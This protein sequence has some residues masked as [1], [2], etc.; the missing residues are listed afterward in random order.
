MDPRVLESMLARTEQAMQVLAEK[1]MESSQNR[2]STLPAVAH[3][4]GGK[5]STHK[6]L[7]QPGK[8]ETRNA[9]L[10]RRRYIELLVARHRFTIIIAIL[11]IVAHACYGRGG[12]QNVSSLSPGKMSQVKHLSHLVSQPSHPLARQLL[13]DHYHLPFSDGGSGSDGSSTQQEEQME[14]Q[15]TTIKGEVGVMTGT[16]VEHL[17]SLPKANRR[18]ALVIRAP[19]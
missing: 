4:A 16:T 3:R 12:S 19:S 15:T 17:T 1:V 10:L 6:G 7:Q 2:V 14:Q 8:S 18:D 11:L 13:A 9:H 5:T